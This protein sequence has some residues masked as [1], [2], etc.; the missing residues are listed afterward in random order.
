[1]SYDD[2]S[3]KKNKNKNKRKQ[4]EDSEEEELVSTPP[5]QGTGFQD[6]MSRGG[7]FSL[8]VLALS[9]LQSPR[10]CFGI[11]FSSR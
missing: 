7:N 5:G 1:M 4:S 11:S 3:S 8:L 2:S 10:P 6:P 9:H